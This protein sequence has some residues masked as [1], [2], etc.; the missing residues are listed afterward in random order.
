MA[1]L[2]IVFMGTPAFAVPTLQGLLSSEHTVVAVYSQ[3]PR[4]AGRGQKLT[5]SA[6]HQLAQS[7]DIAVFTPTSLKT[8]EAQEIFRSHQADIAVV[9]AY[10][11]LL[12]QAILEAP[13]LGCINV[14]PSALP[15]WRGAAPIQ[16]TLMAGD[17]HTECC[18]MQMEVG[19][20]TGPVL[21]REAFAIPP[22]MNAT[23][24]YNAMAALGGA[25]TMRTLEVLDTLSATPQSS[26]EV[27][28]AAKIT[29]DDQ[30]I[31][32][33]REASSTLHQIRGLSFNPAATFRFAGET[34]K[35]TRAAVI[36]SPHMA[37]AGTLISDTGIVA[38]AR[39]TALQLLELQRAGKPRM[40]IEEFLRGFPMPRGTVLT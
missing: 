10:G 28:H 31:M 5:P 9:A 16:R 14:H 38:C 40:A 1:A 24:L 23:G 4:P 3:P 27:T 18:I 32:W 35:V 7:R 30:P 26:V 12:P 25:L 22:D 19:M 29:K 13:K 6:V 11:L 2:R 33:S 20:D 39:G 37:A 15:R 21:M 8:S 17:S 36:T 34:L